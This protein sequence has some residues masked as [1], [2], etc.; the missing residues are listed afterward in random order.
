M[1]TRP[2][3]VAMLTELAQPS[4]TPLLF[5][6][7]DFASGLVRLCTAGSTVPWNG[8]DWL[9]VGLLGTVDTIRENTSLEA[10][11]L[12]LALSGL[13]P[14]VLAIALQESYQGRPA[15]VWLGLLNASGALVAD[16]LL[17]MSARMD[18]MEVTTGDTASVTINV[19]SD[20]AMWARPPSTKFT[21]ADQQRLHPGDKF[22]EYV[23]EASERTIQWGK[24]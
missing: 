5:V 1:S 3:T 14:A 10:T 22:F 9:G 4:I 19:E 6:E 15:R 8:S 16:P 23:T 21:D 13:D 17:L 20:L 24:G 11:G 12:R 18:S 2:A 7:L